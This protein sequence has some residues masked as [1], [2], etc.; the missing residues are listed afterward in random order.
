MTDVRVYH[1]TTT[2]LEDLLTSG[3]S[4]RMPTRADLAALAEQYSTTFEEV[5]AVPWVAEYFSEEI[6]SHSGRVFV[7]TSWRNAKRYASEGPEWLTHWLYAISSALHGT[8]FPVARHAGAFVHLAAVDSRATRLVRDHPRPPVHV[9]VLEFDAEEIRQH[10]PHFT[11]PD[12]IS[13]LL[14]VARDLEVPA[15]IPPSRIQRIDHA[16]LGGCSY[17]GMFKDGSP[18]EKVD[19]RCGACGT[20]AWSR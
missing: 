10:N 15:P 16:H 4:P 5:W 2:H 20:V 19:G 12:E 17:C 8:E 14:D 6:S 3:L 9:V 1:G 11:P 13:E 18:G 7:T